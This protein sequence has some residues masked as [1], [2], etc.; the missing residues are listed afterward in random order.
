MAGA[1]GA[2]TLWLF[3]PVFRDV[4]CF[5]RLRADVLSSTRSVTALEKLDRRFVVIDDT[6]GLDDEIAKLAPLSDTIVIRPPFNLGH[7]RALV[8]G[9]RKMSRR[10]REEDIV[11]TLDTD[12]EDRPEDLPRL[13]APLMQD[14]NH[15]RRLAVASR[16][17]RK[18]SLSFKLMY[19]L[20]KLLFRILTGT[21]INSGNYAAYRGWL[22]R[23]VLAHPYFDLCYSSSLVTLGMDLWYVPCPRGT[24]Y[25]G[26]SRMTFFKLAMHGFRMFM[27]FLDRIAVRALSFFSVIL[28]LA[29]VAATLVVGV[30]FLTT[31]A[32]PGWATF[33]LLLIFIASLMAL[34]NALILFSI[35]AQSHGLL[36][37]GLEGDDDGGA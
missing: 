33:T 16:T 10:M 29:V 15:P 9:L 18:E 36:L 30:R 31:L 21:V 13:L 1:C 20:F 12:G 17:H 34:G 22:V 3:T 23:H 32:I 11:V 8:Y 14:G 2:G 25:A 6:A 5:L 24:R 37:R 28:A 26:R 27:P 35:F 4:E 7:Q 19:R